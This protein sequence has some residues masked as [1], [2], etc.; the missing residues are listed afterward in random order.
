MSSAKLK[1]IFSALSVEVVNVLEHLLEN[2]AGATKC[3]SDTSAVRFVF[4]G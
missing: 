2:D 3:S 4:Q 1:V